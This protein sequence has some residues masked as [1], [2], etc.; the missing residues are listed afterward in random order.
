[1][2]VGRPD[3][4]RA[5]FRHCVP[6]VHAQVQQHLLKLRRVGLDP[7]NLRVKFRTD[8][9]SFPDDSL[10]HLSMFRT[11]S[12]MQTTLGKRGCPPGKGE[13]LL[14]ERRP[15]NLKLSEFR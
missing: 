5:T 4:E 1:V 10:Q 12:L 7:A 8:A 6:G 14:R 9:D 3:T 2:T 15:Q 11:E 13:Q